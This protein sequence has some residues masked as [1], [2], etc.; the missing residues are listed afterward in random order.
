MSTDRIR[1]VALT[2][3]TTAL[4]IGAPGSAESLQGVTVKLFKFQPSPAE[5]AA[6]AKVCWTNQD[7]IAHTITSGTPEKRDGRFNM[8]LNG[9]GATATVEFK[10]PGVYAYF[11]DRH[12]SMR[13]EIR[14]K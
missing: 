12:Q 11:C 9:K 1:E 8:P 13:G 7:D 5:V 6:G 3:A 4:M 14:V 10:D 2:V